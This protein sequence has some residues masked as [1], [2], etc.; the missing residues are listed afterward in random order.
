MRVVTIVYWACGWLIGIWLG[1]VLAL[2]TP[3]CSVV[4][5]LG[6]FMAVLLRRRLVPFALFLTLSAVA[7]GAARYNLGRPLFE[8]NHISSFNGQEEV[9]VRGLVVK[10]PDIR[11]TT[12]VLTVKSESIAPIEGSQLP[13]HGLILVRAQRWPVIT[14]GTRIEAAGALEEPANFGTFDYRAYL[15]N[16]GIVSIMNRPSITIAATQAGSPLMHA[17]TT[18]H[19]RAQESINRLLPQPQAALLS[20]ILLGDDHAIPADLKKDFRDTGMTHIIAISGFNIA[21]IAGALLNG[22]RHIVGRRMAAWIALAGIAA[23]TLFVGADASV[24]RAAVMGTLFVIASSLLGRPTFT[25]AA[26]FAAAFFM[27]LLN[28]AILWDVGFQLSFAATLG[29]MLYVGPW[30]SAVRRRLQPRLGVDAGNMSTRF[31]SEIALTTAAAIVMTLPLLIYHFGSVSLVSPI[32]NLF[33]LPV[34][35]GIMTWGG[36][37]TLAGMASPVLGQPPAWIAWLL[38]SYTIELVTF[39]ST[40]P[41]A[42]V[43]VTLSPFG[44]IA[45]YGFVFA[46]SWLVSSE[47]NDEENRTTTRLDGRVQKT[48]LLGLLL[49]A[50]LAVVWAGQRPDGKLHVVFLD[51]GQ[52]DAILIQS[53]DGNQMLVDGGEYP[54]LLLS[55][56]GEQLPFWDKQ[57]DLVVATHP[58]TDHVAGLADLF[59]NYTVGQVITNGADSENTAIYRA[60]LQAAADSQT[61]VR[62][63]ISGEVIELGSQVTVEILHSGTTSTSL[64]DNNDS[65]ILRLVYKDFSLLLTGDAEQIA[66]QALLKSEKDL[67]STVLKAGHHGSRSASSRPFLRAVAPQVVIISAGKANRFG[68]PHQETLQRLMETG[69]AVWRTDEAGTIELVSDGRQI[70]SNIK[71]EAV[72]IP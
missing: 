15:A 72:P 68:H 51:V 66:E 49:G 40:I 9:V 67:R 12:Q 4:G 71:N 16:R 18:V 58:D 70:W 2:P 43:P 48:I 13:T 22:G 3:L 20:G 59:A 32:A 61:P 62:G 47:S 24:V 8:Q 55:R 44:L 34:Q 30:S 52:G 23:Y 21:V 28:P 54:S 38:L 45:F 56:V 17:L 26:L 5:M 25:A 33:I 31:V 69:A 7:L 46:I 11:E 29:L 19:A 6:L 64:H 35:P 39:F 41:L 27:T 14:Y 1:S 53:P 50:I 36:A 37:A 65:V 63:G 57:I 60:F 10:P 42:A